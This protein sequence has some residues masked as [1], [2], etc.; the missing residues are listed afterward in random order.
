MVSN[1]EQVMRWIVLR[2]MYQV[3]QKQDAEKRLSGRTPSKLL[4]WKLICAF[5]LRNL[6][7][8]FAS[9]K[10]DENLSIVHEATRIREDWSF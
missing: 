9:L 7:D 5:C 1:A 10:S 4:V 8:A 6:R 3:K 2:L